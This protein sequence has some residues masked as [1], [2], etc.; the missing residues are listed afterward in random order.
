MRELFQA[1][2]SAVNAPYTLLLVAMLIYWGGVVLGALDIDALDLDI[3]GDA[4]IDAGDMDADA[5]AGGEGVGHALLT[6]FNLRDVPVTIVASFFI[7]SLWACGILSN[8]YLHRN[9]S[10]LLAAA[11]FIPNLLVSLHVAKFITAPLKP[12]F[13]KM[14]AQV[15]DHQDLVG[16]RC[17][18]TTSEVTEHFGQAEVKTNGAEL[19]LT[20]RTTDGETLKKGDQAV[21]M[22]ELGAKGMYVISK[23]EMEV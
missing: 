19:Q 4:D 20:V 7:L 8:Y 1:S 3:E 17:V 14:K 21:I 5:D 18:V 9:S 12:V 22:E 2:I 23:L 10:E 6:Y 16:K 15:E 13:K 11:L